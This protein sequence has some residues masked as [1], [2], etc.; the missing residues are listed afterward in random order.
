[1]KVAKLLHNPKAGE[2]KYDKTQLIDL[3]ESKGYKCI[4]ASVKKEGWDII[5]S[6]VDFVIVA[7]GDGTVRKT[8]KVL[9]DRKVLDKHIPIAIL[10][11]GTANNISKSLNIIG[12][13]EAIIDSWKTWNIKKFDVGKITGLGKEPMF[14]L[15]GFGFGLFPNLMKEMKNHKEQE[16]KDPVEN[17]NLALSLLQTLAYE[18]QARECKLELDGV[19]HSGKFLLVEIMNT[20]SIGPNLNFNTF[21]DSSDGELEV[22]I[23]PESQREKFIEYMK[24]RKEGIEA[25][26]CFSALKAKDIKISWKGIHTHVDDELIKEK[27]PIEASVEIHSGVLSFLQPGEPK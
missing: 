22:I 6:E 14:L 3:I 17:L 11:M 9:L 20:A 13:T 21:G 16:S 12:E 7:G 1:M 24:D 5:E 18:Y 23:I 2:G 8:A 15:E 27:N 4:Y 10:P 26:F 25:P 19:D